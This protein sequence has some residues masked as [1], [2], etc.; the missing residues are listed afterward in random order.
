MEPFGF[1][2]IKNSSNDGVWR[3]PNIIVAASVMSLASFD[4]KTKIIT[5]NLAD[6]SLD[7]WYYIQ[8]TTINIRSF[9]NKGISI[10][11]GRMLFKDNKF[12]P[13]QGAINRKLIISDGF[14]SASI[15]PSM[16]TVHDLESLKETVDKWI[17]K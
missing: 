10:N 16:F 15:R 5:M 12:Y 2:I 3:L 11:S 17:V 6:P 7:P 13:V 14:N 8:F 1:K 4:P 9:H